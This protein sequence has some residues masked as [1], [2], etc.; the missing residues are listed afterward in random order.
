MIRRLAA[1][2]PGTDVR[3]SERMIMFPS[4]GTVQVKSADNPDSLRGEGLD[5]VV[6]DECAFVKEDAWT[7]ALRPSLADRKGQALFISTP[8][9]RNW[10]WRLWS[11]SDN[12]TWKS[13]RFTSYDNPFLDPSEIDAA[14]QLLPERTF[15][16]EF[17]AD[18][19]LDGGGVFRNIR[20]LA[21]GQFQ[22]NGMHQHTY[23]FGIDWGRSDDF[24]VV[25]VYDLTAK[26]LCHID[27]YNHIDYNIQANRVRALSEK[28]RPLAIVAE[29]NAMGMPILD[30]LRREGLP[31]VPFTTTGASKQIAIDALALA[32]EREQLTMIPD[33][34]LL[35]ELESYT[36]ERLSSGVTRYDAPLGMHDDCV[37]SLAF[38]W[39]GA[40]NSGRRKASSKE[41]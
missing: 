22:P 27:R 6:I 38:A 7:E 37:M 23:I 33:E 17:M 10:F 14:K 21:T 9:G 19:V 8:K 36:S 39:Y 29:T 32:F 40:T 30:T 24:T 20:K 31:I 2:I 16:Q 34:T 18:F 12:K 11:N 1:Q 5:Y 15:L 4:G 25:T 28:F 35:T 41:Y 3:E 26:T 13:W